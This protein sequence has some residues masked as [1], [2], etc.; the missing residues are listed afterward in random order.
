MSLK[1]AKALY[2]DA[3]EVLTIVER[4]DILSR[5]APPGVE[6]G[7]HTYSLQNLR[8]ACLKTPT[9]PI[10][11]RMA[12]IKE[13]FVPHNVKYGPESVDWKNSC[14][15]EVSENTTPARYEENS[16]EAIDPQ[17]ST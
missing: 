6:V 14:Y 12:G 15:M 8:H 9:S 3:W 7:K 4:R 2:G 1:A 16:P 13:A 10:E 11:E 5:P 17:R